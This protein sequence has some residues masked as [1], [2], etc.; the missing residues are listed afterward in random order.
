MDRIYTPLFSKI[1]YQALFELNFTNRIQNQAWLGT[2]RMS[3]IVTRFSI[4][5]HISSDR[6]LLIWFRAVTKRYE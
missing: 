4:E 5:L 2:C 1:W 6:N 3:K